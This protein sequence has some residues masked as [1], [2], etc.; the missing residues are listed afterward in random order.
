MPAMVIPPGA[1][2]GALANGTVVSGGGGAVGGGVAPALAAATPASP[3]MAAGIRSIR[4]EIPRTGNSFLFT[5]VLNVEN[6]PLSVRAKMVSLQSF[7]TIQMAGQV[8][9]FVLGLLVW[10]WQW[11][12]S[13]RN[14]F[15][16]TLALALIIASVC[17]LLIAW[18]A[19]H[20]LL[21]VGFPCVTLA[22]IAYLVWKYWPRRKP[23]I[24]PPP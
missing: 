23:E 20:D 8:A 10:W 2:A 5:K 9:A 6:E 15:V 18:R 22:A 11:R 13:R 4:I 7:Q 19:L 16:L 21:I 24:S 14:S 3:P 17:S 1:L 12:R